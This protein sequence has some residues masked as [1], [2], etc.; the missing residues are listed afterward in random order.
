[1]ERVA[2]KEN[3][4][5]VLHDYSGNKLTYTIHKT[6]GNNTGSHVIAYLAE[7]N[8]HLV[9]L[10]EF[11]PIRTDSTIT[12]T[13][14]NENLLDYRNNG[15]IYRLNRG[16]IN[17]SVLT[18][19]EMKYKNFGES[20]E[21][22]YE[23]Y[24]DSELQAYVCADF[25]TVFHLLCDNN[26]NEI[27]CE[28]AFFS[29]SCSLFDA[30]E[31]MHYSQYNML[32]AMQS[33]ML[34]LKKLHDKGYLLIDFKPEDV[35]IP[36]DNDYQKNLCFNKVLFYDFG[37]VKRIGEECCISELQ[38]TNDYS[39]DAYSES[40]DNFR[41][42]KLSVSCENK[43][44]SNVFKKIYDK[45]KKRDSFYKH[46]V[47]NDEID[48][49]I[50]DVFRMEENDENGEAERRL[51]NIL[52][53]CRSDDEKYNKENRD[54]MNKRFRPTLVC[55]L[56]ISIILYLITGYN[57]ILLCTKNA[58]M[59]LNNQMGLNRI[60]VISTGFILI[61]LF[62]IK[63]LI[64]RI[65]SRIARTIVC[66][67]YY[68]DNEDH[69]RDILDRNG[70]PVYKE[71]LD[72]FSLRY[73]DTMS[74]SDKVRF[75]I[76][77]RKNSAFVDYSPNNKERQGLRHVMWIVLFGM[78][79]GGFFISVKA[80][81]FPLF[82][83]L[84]FLS[85]ILFMYIDVYEPTKYFFKACID[86]PTKRHRLNRAKYYRNEYIGNNHSFELNDEY[87]K[88]SDGDKTLYR[89]ILT[90]K[91]DLNSRICI[92]KKRKY[93]DKLEEYKK[94]IKQNQY[95]N[96]GIP[97]FHM[98]HIYKMTFDR[99]SNRKLIINGSILAL[100]ISTLILDCY[101]FFGKN[102]SYLRTPSKAYVIITSIVIIITFGF[103]VWQIV[104]AME[105]ELSIA[106][107][108][109]K[110][111]YLANNALNDFL[112]FD[113]SLGVVSELDI[114]RG[115]NQAEG[116]IHTRNTVN[117]L[118][119]DII[120]LERIYRESSQRIK[121]HRAKIEK[122]KKKQILTSYEDVL[123]KRL[124]HH[125]VIGNRRRV[126]LTIWMGF[127]ILFSLIS[128]NE[129]L[130]WTA[131]IF[132][133]FCGLLNVLINKCFLWRIIVKRQIKGMNLYEKEEIC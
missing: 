86:K 125:E 17:N 122:E 61:S 42:I 90:I 38:T 50:S 108:S 47:L 19:I 4:I 69:Y 25:F 7:R 3:S 14:N 65:S 18:D 52:S 123:N 41:Q 75:W 5:L 72:S 26:G 87:Y 45:K 88:Q 100:T 73:D 30:A 57:M 16:I 102:N 78:I 98:W 82:F 74:F 127:G 34:F 56:I 63:V 132:I 8:N 103:S 1:M 128:W 120:S 83:A 129:K 66:C 49:F 113:I 97:E 36:A 15:S 48:V 133:V 111:R 20:S 68:E 92:E 32:Q 2:I 91:D 131:P 84:G 119:S 53:K 105:T 85:I 77:G 110:S 67:D 106:E 117:Q 58:D 109:Y 121:R 43:T 40:A 28:N 124:L 116:S 39:T 79:L 101:A 23:Y 60:I 27:Y 71:N 99:L 37:S 12:I 62:G 31:D 107:M 51:N 21:R 11:Y 44:Y 46:D 95:V 64:S 81:S 96:L 29:N 13:R 35:L 104:N 10:K 130:F 59:S 126:T 6:I 55:L 76:N 114:I 112:V 93:K 54:K 94:Y 22:M 33:C 24:I 9:V 80:N 115:I 89:N 70:R 118:R